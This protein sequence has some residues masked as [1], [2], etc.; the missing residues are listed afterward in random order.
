MFSFFNDVTKEQIKHELLLL[1]LNL[2][3]HLHLCV[4]LFCLLCSYNLQEMLLLQSNANPFLLWMPSALLH[5]CW[6]S[7]L[8]RKISHPKFNK[9]K[10]NTCYSKTCSFCFLIY[11]GRCHLCVPRCSSQ[12]QRNILDSS[13]CHHSI[14]ST[15]RS[16]DVTLQKRIPKIVPIQFLHSANGVCINS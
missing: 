2:L 6:I 16:W 4:L 14:Q 11:I 1:P 8:E 9:T 3:G 10:Q 12:N 5:L 15:S 13:F 7:T